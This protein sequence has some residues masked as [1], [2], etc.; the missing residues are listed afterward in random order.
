MYKKTFGDYCGLPGGGQ[1]SIVQYYWINS[2]GKCCSVMLD[3]YVAGKGI[4]ELQNT[5]IHCFVRKST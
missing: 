3:A 4:L 2:A 5:Q 1:Y